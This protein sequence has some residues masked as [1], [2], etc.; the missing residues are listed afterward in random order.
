MPVTVRKYTAPSG[1]VTVNLKNAE[2]FHR[3]ANDGTEMEIHGDG[4][5]T[6]NLE[7]GEYN[8]FSK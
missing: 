1:K 2:G 8:Y 7:P 3:N 4:K 5:A 6:A